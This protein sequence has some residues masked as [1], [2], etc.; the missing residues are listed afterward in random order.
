[1]SSV[2]A[3]SGLVHIHSYSYLLAIVC[4]TYPHAANQHLCWVVDEIVVRTLEFGRRHHAICTMKPAVVEP[5]DAEKCF[6][7]EVT[8]ISPAL[9]TFDQFPLVESVEALG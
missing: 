5:I 4:Q 3:A 1:M 7:F 2:E 9:T 6:P 8:G